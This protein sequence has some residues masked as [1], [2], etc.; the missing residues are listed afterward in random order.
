MEG[1]LTDTFNHMKT[2]DLFSIKPHTKPQGRGSLSPN[3]ENDGGNEEY[4]NPPKWEKVSRTERW[5][6]KTHRQ[7]DYQRQLRPKRGKKQVKWVQDYKNPLEEQGKKEFKENPKRYDPKA[8]LFNDYSRFK[9][10]QFDI[11]AQSYNSRF[12]LGLRKA[13][14]KIVSEGSYLDADK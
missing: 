10:N 5:Y 8:H 13:E 12:S 1:L 4:I 7:K 2:V 6:I 11:S 9:K 14:E 3:E